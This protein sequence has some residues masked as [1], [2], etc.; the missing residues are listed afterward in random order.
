[1]AY[2]KRDWKIRYSERS[3]MST[4]VVHLTKGNRK[5]S[6]IK[7]VYKILNDKRIKG[8][9]TDSGFI[10]GKNSAVCF[11]D[12][13][14]HSICQNCWFEQKLRENDE[15]VRVRY[16][17]T[18]FLFHKQLVH[19]AGGRPV[20]YDNTVAAKKYLPQ[21]EWWRIVNFDLTNDEQFIDWTHEREWRVKGD[22]EFAL[23]DVTLLFATSST[24][25]EFI[26]YCDSQD[27][28][29]YKEVAGVIVTEQVFF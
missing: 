28:P 27:N 22:F 13:P 4:S 26:Q 25:Q 18:G 2:T 17:P 15:S 5:R 6:T 9:T 19:K 14:M 8:S 24:Y 16:Q 29:L 21:E 3:D 23:R 7:T 12:A 20:I 1:M 11:Q 10:V